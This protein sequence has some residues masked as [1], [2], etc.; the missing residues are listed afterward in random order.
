[1]NR[2]PPAPTPP[3]TPPAPLSTGTAWYGKVPARGDF[4]SHGLTP[5]HVR[6]W[7]GWLQQGIKHAARRWPPDALER[8]LLTFS[9]WRFLAWPGGVAG[10][11]WTGV[12]VASHDRVGRA[13][14]LMVLQAVDPARLPGLDW[15]DIEAA[16]ARM[17]DAALDTTDLA[18]PQATEDFEVLL[19]GLGEVFA[20]GRVAARVAMRVEAPSD[21]WSMRPQQAPLDLLRHSPGTQS[22]WWTEPVPGTAPLPLGDHW[23]PHAEL[24]L[25]ILGPGE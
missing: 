3:P 14:P 24:M 17:A 16:L 9:P 23:P 7:D 6:A 20:P 10:T 8:R 25:D 11:A 13:F 19:L 18:D 4:V 15:L 22:L 5:P 1:M 21:A 2:R 12:L